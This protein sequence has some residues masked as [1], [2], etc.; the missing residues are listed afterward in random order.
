MLITLLYSNVFGQKINLRFQHYTIDNGLSQNTVDCILK[1]SHGFM[2]FGTWNGLNRFDGYNFV[3]YK[4]DNH[5]NS[6]SGNFIYSLCEDKMGNIWIGTKS[7]LNCFIYSQNIFKRCFLNSSKQSL[8]NISSVIT[9]Y[10]GNLWVGTNTGLF[11]FSSDKVNFE[12]LSASSLKINL[13]ADLIKLSVNVVYEDRDNNIWVGTNSGLIFISKDKK[14]YKVFVNSPTD[15]NSLSYSE[16]NSIYEDQYSYVWIG[17]RFGLNR[18][19][20]KNFRNERFYYNPDNE[21][22]ISHFTI[23]DIIGDRYGNILIATLGGL[24]R[25]NYKSGT[26]EHFPFNLNNDYSLNNEFVN[27]L[28]ADNQGNIWV[29]TDK[30]GVN[31][32][33]FYQKQFGYMSHEPANKNSLTC[34][35]VNSLF[36]EPDKLWIGTA[37]GG[38]NVYHKNT[39]IFSSYTSNLHSTNRLSKDYVSAILRDKNKNLW[40]ATWGGGINKL[41]SENGQGVFKSYLTTTN[42]N[43]ICD[44]YISSLCEDRNGNILIGALYGLDLFNPK[45]ESFLHIASNKKWKKHISEVGC[46]LLDKNGYYWIG[47]RIGLFRINSKNIYHVDNE[48]CIE[49]FVNIPGDSTSIPGNYVTSLCQDRSGAIWIGTYGNGFCKVVTDSKSNVSFV[50]YNDK[51]GLANNVVYAILD[52]NQGNLWLSTDNGLSRFDKENKTFKNFYVKDGLQSNQFYWTSACK[53]VDGKMYFGGVEGLN[54]FVPDSIKDYPFA[55]Q[56]VITDLKIFNTSV[57]VGVWNNK[58]KI[59]DEVISS[60]K[61]LKLSYKENVFSFEFSA[62]DYYLPEKIQYAYMMQ[63][64]DNSWVYVP[65]SRRFANYTNLKGGEYV[66]MVKAQNSD[67]VWSSVPTTIKIIITPP[68]WETLWFRIIAILIISIIIVLYFQIRTRNLQSRK[69]I[70]EKMVTDRTAQIEKQKVQLEL[71]NKEILVQRDQLIELNEKVQMV[72]QFKLRFFTNISHEFRTP[73]TLIIDPLEQLINTFREN[74]DVISTLKTI[75]RNA[76]RLL[77]LINQLIYFRRIESGKVFVKVGK[78]DF[79][80]FLF[81]I[82]ESFQDLAQHQ[83]INYSFTTSVELTEAWFDSEKIE[84]IFY[85]LLSNAFKNTPVKGT[86][87]MNVKKKSEEA[88]ANLVCIEVIDTGRGISEEFLPFIFGQFYQ[89]ENQPKSKVDGSGIGLALTSEIVKALHGRIEVKSKVGEGSVFTVFLPYK[90]EAFNDKEID[91]NPISPEINID[92]KVDVLTHRIIEPK[93]LDLENV[94]IETA[95]KSN[96]LILIIEDNYDL[97]AFLKKT[98]KVDFRI[99]TAENGSEG[100][101]Q[102]KKYSP[103]LIVSDVMMPVMDGLELCSQLKAD[104]QTCHIPIILLTARNMVEDWV[105][106]LETGADDYIP[107]PFSLDILKARIFNLIESR[108]KLMKMFSMPEKFSIE[109]VTSNSADEE[110]IKRAYAVLESKFKIEGFNSNQLAA[111]M[112]M[113]PSLL[114]K[115]IKALTDLNVID[116]IN[117]FKL[118]KALELLEMEQF[119]MSDIAFQAGFNDPKYFS[120]LFRKFYGMSPSEFIQV[121]IRKE[122]NVKHSAD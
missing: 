90:K 60:T 18:I 119:P 80:A 83:N 36:D 25:F 105:V 66:F 87:Q 96:P 95:Q 75:N 20:K 102:A 34:N 45:E 21:Y 115:K 77:Y 54:Y 69:R 120:R 16:I 43:S 14:S 50:N 101:S 58:K 22:G 97:R 111:D 44:V 5:P 73:L 52:D 15:L 47:S 4:S 17:T 32:F 9:D 110:F 13:P 86:I 89:V 6:L 1:D 100:L 92:D 23:N 56:V 106:G 108:R 61:E 81:Q 84:N 121:K 103:D 85:N 7:G 11:L 8:G 53:G 62:L 12:N 118:R 46:L 33:S 116:F 98:L 31:K 38:L 40:V 48:K 39:G 74:E 91:L 28:Y 88:G 79:T 30:G 24:N 35:T 68:F 76:Q 41:I 122:D 107:K 63:G 67:G 112:F 65:S 51:S 113:S 104:I 64:V 70:L 37:G 71:Q 117:T 27:S 59:L 114:Y 26:F 42:P 99:I 78:G 2:W 94:D 109:E 29:G 55:P 19:N 3:V 93:S 82:F 10:E 49:K 72:N 57:N